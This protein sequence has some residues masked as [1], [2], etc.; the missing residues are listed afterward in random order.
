MSW[1][2]NDHTEHHAGVGERKWEIDS[3]CYTIRLA[4]GYWKQTGD[5][6]PFDAAWKEAAWTIVRT[7]KTQQRKDGPGPYSFQREAAAP[8]DSVPLRCV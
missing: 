4:Y 7:F 1:A 3:L 2:V 6:K 5:T 8:S